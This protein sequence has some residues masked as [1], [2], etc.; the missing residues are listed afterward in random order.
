MLLD[1]KV[2]LNRG[3]SPPKLKDFLKR[4]DAYTLHRRVRRRIPR[5]PYSVNNI[6]DVWECDLI[7][8]HSLRKNLTMIISFY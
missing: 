8:L 3:K 6:L 7:D 1:S 5:N 4:Q 2:A